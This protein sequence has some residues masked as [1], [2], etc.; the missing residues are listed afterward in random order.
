MI[1]PEGSVTISGQLASWLGA[2][3]LAA[4]T[5]SAA[6][7]LGTYRTLTEMRV[8]L[9]ALADRQD[10]LE[11]ARL[12]DGHDRKL[13]NGELEQRLRAVEMNLADVNATLRILVERR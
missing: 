9:R 3:S 7:V 11:A 10:V 5:A 12:G 2:L 8:E 13:D 1:K 6:G 4:I